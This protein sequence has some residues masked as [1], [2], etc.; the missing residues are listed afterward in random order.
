MT[1]CFT[2]VFQGRLSDFEGNPFKVETVFGKA[3]AVSVG[4]AL[5]E[6]DELRAR[7]VQLCSCKASERDGQHMAWCPSISEERP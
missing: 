1:D 4:N 6:N 3:I 2:I 7:Q 5:E